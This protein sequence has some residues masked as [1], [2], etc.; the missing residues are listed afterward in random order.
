MQALES[1]PPA[2]WAFNAVFLKTA[3]TAQKDLPKGIFGSY[4][5]IPDSVP[6]SVKGGGRNTSPPSPENPAPC[7]ASPSCGP[8]CPRCPTFL[9][10]V[11][12]AE[13]SRS[14]GEVPKAHPTGRCS[15]CSLQ[16][17]SHP[18]SPEQM[19]PWEPPLSRA[20]RTQQGR[21]SPIPPRL[22]PQPAGQ[23][24]SLGFPLG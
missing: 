24:S 12:G 10:H 15:G 4:S 17:S 5:A 11:S 8:V 21:G 6:F 23:H 13:A 3:S 16:P 9:P 14:L 7:P 18:L 22:C 2:L 20:W 19:Q 1:S